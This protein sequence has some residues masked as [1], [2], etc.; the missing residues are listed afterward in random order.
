MRLMVVGFGSTNIVATRSEERSRVSS[1]CVLN[2]WL[3]PDKIAIYPLKLWVLYSQTPWVGLRCPAKNAF[4]EGKHKSRLR[5][6]PTKPPGKACHWSSQ[7]ARESSM[8]L[9]IP[10]GK[11]SPRVLFTFICKCK[12]TE[13]KAEYRSITVESYSQGMLEYCDGIQ[14]HRVRRYDEVIY[15]PE[16]LNE[17]P[18]C[19][20]SILYR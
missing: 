3:P 18:R 6:V 2:I 9:G 19:R 15:S 1:R 11:Y 13:K 20:S 5:I 12:E 7:S 17:V 14:N 8:A 10:L 4:L 16:V